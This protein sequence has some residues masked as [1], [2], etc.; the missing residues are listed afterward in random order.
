MDFNLYRLL[1]IFYVCMVIIKRSLVALGK[2]VIKFFFAAARY[3]TEIAPGTGYT[4]EKAGG[5]IR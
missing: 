4:Q 1:A 5:L 3:S 2:K